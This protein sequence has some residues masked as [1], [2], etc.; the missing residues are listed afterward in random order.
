M[1]WGTGASR[2]HAASL[3][4]PDLARRLLIVAASTLI[5]G[6]DLGDDPERSSERTSGRTELLIRVSLGVGEPIRTREISCPDRPPRDGKRVCAKVA[7]ISWEQLRP[8]PRERICTANTLGPARARLTGLL[9]GKR[10]MAVFRLT[11]GCEIGRWQ[12]LS[13]L[14]GDP[15]RISGARPG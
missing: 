8:V 15:R 9:R 1:S 3:S 11:D 12:R 5:A 7:R 10:V 13:Y 6:C 2:N 14:L 4:R